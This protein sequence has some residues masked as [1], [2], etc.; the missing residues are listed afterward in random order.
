MKV[1][2]S[3]IETFF[4]IV[5]R[6]SEIDELK[7]CAGFQTIKFHADNTNE[8]F[9]LKEIHRAIT[10]LSDQAYGLKNMLSNI[11]RIK[12]LYSN[13]KAN[14]TEWLN[15]IDIYMS[16]L[17]EDKKHGVTTIY[18]VIGYDIGIG[19][20]KKVCV[21]LNSEICLDDIR[22]LIS[23][24]IH[25]TAHTY[26]EELHGSAFKV[27]KTETMGDLINM[28]HDSIHYEGVGI[29]STED[30][31]VKNNLPN[32]GSRIQ[33]DYLIASCE[34]MQDQLK[35][36]YR[37]LVKDLQFGNIEDTEEFM[38]RTFGNS[39]LAHRL[40]YYVFSEIH[41]VDGMDGVRKAIN[42]DYKV[43]AVRYLN[44]I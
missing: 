1:D 30:Y 7:N 38:N 39:K 40:G 35:N 41:K 43:F 29:F 18:P 5:E 33:D 8:S 12:M 26:Y 4:N 19:I 44:D 42:M 20:N 37:T 10:G 3:Y 32:S 22:E 16:N 36:E 11:N 6:K 25:E 24:I 31:R 2:Y 23:I 21:N 14:E 27:S 13:L 9:G 34:K 15:E 28:L 17:F